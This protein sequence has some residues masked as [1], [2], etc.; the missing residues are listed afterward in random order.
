MFKATPATLTNNRWIGKLALACLQSSPEHWQKYN[1]EG[2][3]KFKHGLSRLQF[4]E[5]Q[6]SQTCFPL[7]EQSVNRQA[8]TQAVLLSALALPA[9]CSPSF[10]RQSDPKAKAN[11]ICL[12]CHTEKQFLTGFSY[13]TFLF[14][15]KSWY[16]GNDQAFLLMP[17]LQLPIAERETPHRFACPARKAWEQS[18]RRMLIM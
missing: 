14:H 18:K 2:F 11:K 10:L 16:Q 4:I 1:K 6:F 9:V 5:L 13:F 7:A 17:L 8:T 3:F 15:A 12:L